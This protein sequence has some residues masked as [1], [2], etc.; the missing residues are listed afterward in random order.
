[1]Y[2]FHERDKLNYHLLTVNL[3]FFTSDSSTSDEFVTNHS[4]TERKEGESYKGDVETPVF[5]W[6]R[7]PYQFEQLVR[8]L[9]GEHEAERLCVSQPVNVSHNVAF[10]VNNAKIKDLN[11]LKCDDMGVWEHNGSPKRLFQARFDKRG[12]V[13]GIIFAENECEVVGSTYALKRVYYVNKSSSDVRKI[14]STIEGKF[15][16]GYYVFNDSV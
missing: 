11:D 6:R 14:M 15:D 5:A 1:M 9:L 4:M 10:L 8:I 16:I 7:E 13:K 2:I 3:F 12:E